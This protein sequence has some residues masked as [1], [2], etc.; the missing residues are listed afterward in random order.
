[1]IS[2]EEGGLKIS[3]SGLTGLKNYEVGYMD[4]HSPNICAEPDGITGCS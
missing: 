2:Q 1:M 4:H 3:L